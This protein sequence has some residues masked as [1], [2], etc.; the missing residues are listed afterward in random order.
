[1]NAYIEL[2]GVKNG[3]FIRN[4]IY[5][6]EEAVSAIKKLR[7]ECN[8][9][10]IYCCT[11]IFDK[12]ERKQG[13]HY[14]S[15]L[16]L[17]IDGDI[18]TNE[19]F[20]QVRRAVL[21]LSAVLSIELGIKPNEIRYY[22]SGSKG[23]HLLIAPTVLGIKPS[24][25][26]NIIYKKFVLY[27]KSKVFNKELVDTRIYDNKR[28]IRLANS[29]NAKTNLFKIPVTR[30]IISSISRETLINMAKKPQGEYQV[31]T[32]LNIEAQTKFQRIISKINKNKI[33]KNKSTVPIQIPAKA[34][35]LPICI[36]HIVES[37]SKRGTRNNTLAILASVLVQHG[38]NRQQGGK[39][40]MA[41]NVNNEEPLQPNE[42][43]LTYMSA[44]KMAREGK[45]Y[46]CTSIRALDLFETRNVC[47]NCK[48]Y[49]N[50]NTR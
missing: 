33:H 22:F 3:Y 31:S 24:E 7:E 19:G 29:I 41:W 36:K 50:I 38:F 16:Y 44:E 6:K 15:P 40:I 45:R 32:Q 43:R 27:L 20:E 5:P 21:S 1:M 25:D 18:S 14:L 48:I 13:T 34:I 47:P 9:T 39:I 11:Y 42:L 49:Q 8:N 4:R 35:P 26:L 2:G 17:D 46:G 10:D 30:E 23:F 37:G 28:L 12:K